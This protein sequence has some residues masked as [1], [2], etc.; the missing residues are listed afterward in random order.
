MKNCILYCIFALLLTACSGINY[1]QQLERFEEMNRTDVPLTPDSVL[2]LV[3]HYDHWWHSRNHRMRA[4]Y[5]LGCAYRDQGSAPRALENYQRAVNVADTTDA[6]CDLNTLMRVHSQMAQIFLL[7]RL[8]EQE[9]QELHIAERLAWQIGDTLSALIFEERFC[10]ILYDK[11]EYLTCIKQTLKLYSQ[12][13][14]ARYEN[15][16]KLALVNCI[17]SYFE[18]GDYSHAK[19]Y[20]DQYETCPYLQNNL[21]KV[22]GGIRALYIYKGQYFNGVNQPDSAEYYLKKALQHQDIWDSKLLIT[23]GLCKTYELKQDADSVLKYTQLYSNAKESSFDEARTEATI[24]TKAMYDYS[25]EKELAQKK[26]Q[27]ARRLVLSLVL[28]GLFMV[29]TSLYF[30]Y[31]N[32]K[33]KREISE[34]RE[35]YQQ[36]CNELKSKDEDIRELINRQDV[37]EDLVEKYKYEKE[38]LMIAL[39]RL[40]QTIKMKSNGDQKIDLSKTTIVDRFKKYRNTQNKDYIIEEEHWKELHDTINSVSPTFYLRVN[41]LQQLSQ[42]DYRVCMLVYAGFSSTDISFFMNF[43]ESASSNSRRR[44]N[45]KVFGVDGTPAEFDHKLRLL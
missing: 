3:R 45:K 43:S 33:R 23:K 44:L 14:S 26:A 13:I 4:Y 35:Q 25:I 38:E 16:A 19:K 20:L 39:S 34:L 30:L 27:T 7:Q 17:K 15:E 24:Q 21:E 10:N 12:Y 6:R 32:E 40:D 42:N 36:I 5:M 18:I 41:A 1:E 31:R 8:P 2:P 28:T 22:L 11:K 9:E 37:G 29:L